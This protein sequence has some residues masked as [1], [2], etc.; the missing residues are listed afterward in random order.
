MKKLGLTKEIDKLKDKFKAVIN[1]DFFDRERK[2]QEEQ[3]SKNADTT[4][5]AMP[6]PKVET[7][8]TEAPKP[9]QSA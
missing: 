3:A 7:N 1:K 4:N 9:V 8:K 5:P 2:K 6:A